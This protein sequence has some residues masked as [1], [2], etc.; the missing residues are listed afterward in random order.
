MKNFK[1]WYFKPAKWWEF[2]LPQSGIEGGV[3]LGAVLSLILFIVFN[4]MGWI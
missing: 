3:I 4:I 1:Q 2:W